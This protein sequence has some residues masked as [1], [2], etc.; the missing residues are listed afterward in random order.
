MKVVL[1][2]IELG[3]Q[4]GSFGVLPASMT[5]LSSPKYTLQLMYYL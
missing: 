4:C 5:L 3:E 2:L 1:F